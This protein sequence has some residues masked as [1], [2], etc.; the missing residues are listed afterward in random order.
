MRGDLVDLFPWMAPEPESQY[1]VLV[2]RLPCLYG[3]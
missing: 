1:K 3:L 2:E